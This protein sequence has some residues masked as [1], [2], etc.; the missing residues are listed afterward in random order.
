MKFP[1]QIYYD[2][3]RC[4]FIRG[5]HGIDVSVRNKNKHVK[6]DSKTFLP[7]MTTYIFTPMTYKIKIFMFFGRSRYIKL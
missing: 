1:H 7:I 2:L 6:L 3:Y 4:S 5:L